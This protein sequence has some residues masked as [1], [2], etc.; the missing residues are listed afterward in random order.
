MSIILIGLQDKGDP[1][2]E[3]AVATVGLT[4]EEEDTEAPQFTQK[5][6]EG[7]KITTLAE[8]QNV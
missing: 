1:N 8:T 3:G 5:V 2:Q 4:F 7:R 6:Y